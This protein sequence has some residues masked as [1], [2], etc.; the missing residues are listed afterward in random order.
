[1]SRFLQVRL[2]QFYVCWHKPT[3]NSGISSGLGYECYHS[4]IRGKKNPSNPVHLPLQKSQ[5]RMSIKNINNNRRHVFWALSRRASN[6][7]LLTERYF[8]QARIELH[9]PRSHVPLFP[10]S[11]DILLNFVLYLPLYTS[12]YIPQLPFIQHGTCGQ[13]GEESPFTEESR[14]TP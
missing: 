7:I 6:C 2:V 12:V 5:P 14:S 11:P 3:S 13:P 1:M 9:P 10:Y 4:G 8:F